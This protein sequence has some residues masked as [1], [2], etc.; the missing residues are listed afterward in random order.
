MNLRRQ[1]LLSTLAT[2]GA[3]SKGAVLVA[4]ADDNENTALKRAKGRVLALATSYSGL[5]DPDYTKQRSFEP[6]IS[7]L[8]DLNSQRPV[9]ERLGLIVGPWKQVWGPYNYRNAERS[10]D[11]EIG[12]NEIYQVVFSTGFY[13]NV[14]PLYERGDKSRER[15][16]LLRGEYKLDDQ[17]SNVLLVRFTR[18]PGFKERPAAGP[19]LF[20]LPHLLETGELKNDVNIVPTWIVRAFFGG[21]A[22]KE[23]YTD[24]TLRI[25]YG[26][27]SSRFENPALYVMTRVAAA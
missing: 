4:T 9:R 22:L 26:A 21:G 17:Q 3:Q 13:Y 27:S 7:E 16:A 6:L 8:L 24:S 19:E 12:V 2:I 15:I 1:I 23:V 25:L 5:G 14:T 11:P 10:V 20:E 18:Y